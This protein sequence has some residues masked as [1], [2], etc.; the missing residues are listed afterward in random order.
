M[1]KWFRGLFTPPFFPNDEDKTRKAALLHSILLITLILTIFYAISLPFTHTKPAVYLLLVAAIL[2]FL[3]VALIRIKSGGISQAA[4]GFT[5]FSWLLFTIISFIGG[6]LKSP[7]VSFYF[8]ITVVAG[9]V[10]GSK[11]AVI[12]TILS[13]LSLLGML[14]ADTYQLLPPAHLESTKASTW[15]ILTTAFAGT[16][17]ILLLV[18]RS[19]AAGL[20]ERDRVT[21]ALH[22]R[23]ATF[24]ALLQAL[25]DTIF[26]VNPE[27]V[28]ADYIPSADLH[29]LLP[30]EDF[31][32]KKVADTLPPSLANTTLDYVART[33]AT[34]QPQI[35]EYLLEEK[36]Y[37]ARL[38][39]DE[40][41]N[42]VIV[43]R[44]ITDHAEAQAE[45]EQL[46]AALERRNAQLHTAAEVSKSCSGIFDTQVLIEKAVNLIKDG[47]DVYY[48]GLFL[49]NPEN[50]H[51][52][53]KSGS[54]AAGQQMLEA[55]HQLPL[56]GQSMV[57]WC[58]RHNRARIAQQ[59]TLDQVWL[60][61]PYLP[62]TRSELALPL[63]SR[64]QVIGALTVQSANENAFT[65]GDIAVLQAMAEQLAITIDN[66][67]LFTELQYELAERKKV[68]FA[69]RSSEEKFQKIFKASPVIITIRDQEGRYINV[70]D[71]FTKVT[72]YT[73]EEVLGKSVQ[74]IGYIVN[75][76]EWMQAQ[77]SLER[78]GSF[79]DL[80]VRVERKDGKHIFVLMNSELTMLDG[81]PC[82]LTTAMD[83]TERRQA[84]EALKASEEK[85]SKAFHASPNAAFIMR[86]SDHKYLEVNEAFCTLTGFEREEMLS[87]TALDLNIFGKT[88]A[89]E[90]AIEM[91]Q[92]GGLLRNFEF[93][94]TKKL[95]QTGVGLLSIDEI[96]VN[97]EAC[98]LI[99]IQD[100]TNQKLAALERDLL[101]QEL[102]AKNAEL[103]RF[104]YTV[105]HDLKSPLVTIRGFAGYLEQDMQSRDAE[106][107]KSD[108]TRIMGAAEK[109]QRLLD[110]LLELSRIGRLIN[111]PEE[112]PFNEV[113]R[114]AVS[115]VE[116]QLKSR[117]VEV[118]IEP[119][120]PSVYGDKVRLVEIVQ[121]LLD[122]AAKFMGDQ[123]KPV[124]E[125]GAFGLPEQEPVFFVKDNGIG[126]PAAYQERVFGLFDKLDPNTEGTGVGLALVKRIIE[127]HGGKIWLESGG[128]ERGTTFFFTLPKPKDVTLP[129]K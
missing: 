64:D 48:V 15:V 45:R 35:F 101:I 91:L 60:Q 90:Q 122:N 12:V 87:K 125:I 97:Q 110:E 75:Y 26:R 24:S 10:I 11:A 47:L 58:I 102:S 120:L 83:V 49:V 4:I 127:V 72:G 86:A 30:P 121:N 62:E 17:G 111:P 123:Q 128:T 31:L 98:F 80:V 3:S 23:N 114:E 82:V 55:G 65:E 73:Y 7:T 105:S 13:I 69:L 66:A 107:L 94:F 21:Q 40:A 6:G 52:I 96:V 88:G 70:N 104:T 79:A 85:F 33:L 100:V 126:I 2:F 14:L 39:P 57:A 81:H 27:G 59:T 109:M 36:S 20:R 32:G 56:D 93:T 50:Q 67:N 29:T 116:G 71:T 16:A 106:R 37:E 28:W 117:Q 1:K 43:V 34:Q 25:P 44:D 46:V 84:E 61:N 19:I 22:E 41:G 113:A 99:L 112:I 103:E 38:A 68:E 63:I 124:I 5:L 119:D 8:L 42:V 51:A 78:I 92:N 74:E 89:P 53:L 76:D 118:R 108:V 95:G 129:A 9:L 54:G 115:L 18:N 77:E